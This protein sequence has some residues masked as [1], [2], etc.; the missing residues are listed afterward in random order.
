MFLLFLNTVVSSTSVQ[1][2]RI[3]VSVFLCVSVSWAS[4]ERVGGMST[5]QSEPPVWTLSRQPTC[6]LDPAGP[7]APCELISLASPSPSCPPRLCAVP[8]RPRGGAPSQNCTSS[9]HPSLALSPLFLMLAFC[10]PH[11]LSSSPFLFLGWL[12]SWFVKL[13]RARIYSWRGHVW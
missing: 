3:G 10:H 6:L 13:L 1:C 4:C 9:S 12:P 7:L 2:D 5:W 8:A 11:Q